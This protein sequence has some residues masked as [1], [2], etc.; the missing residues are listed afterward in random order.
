MSI[1]CR[2]PNRRKEGLPREGFGQLS[3]AIPSYDD[4]TTVTSIR[5]SSLQNVPDILNVGCRHKIGILILLQR[6][7][8]KH[9][10]HGTVGYSLS[11]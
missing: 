11:F 9:L 6:C 8:A 7:C 2:I 4:A 3:D 5:T 10:Q 1:A